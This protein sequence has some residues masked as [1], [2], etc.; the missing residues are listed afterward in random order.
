MLTPRYKRSCCKGWG[1]YIKAADQSVWD[2]PTVR[3]DCTGCVACRVYLI[4]TTSTGFAVVR[5]A[6]QTVV[7]SFVRAVD[8]EGWIRTQFAAYERG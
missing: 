4:K 3:V 5:R 6:D 8:A 7:R 1:H 2:V